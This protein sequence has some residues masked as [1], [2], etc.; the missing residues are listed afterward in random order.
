VQISGLSQN[1]SS[2]LASSSQISSLPV[3]TGV[4][5][6]SIVNSLSSTTNDL[7]TISAT[8]NAL[9]NVVY[10]G[11]LLSTAVSLATG[12]PL[13]LP[14][15]TNNVNS[16]NSLSSA[17]GVASDLL[18]NVP[19]AALS[20]TN[21][22]N[23]LFS[24]ISLA[25]GLQG[26]LPGSIVPNL[27]SGSLLPTPVRVVNGL[28]DNVPNAGVVTQGVSAIPKLISSAINQVRLLLI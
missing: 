14:T 24:A 21:A 20:N 27:S 3:K 9:P 4:G 17:I 2:I 18:G 6:S 26:N 22:G 16:G 1:P 19:T 25:T 15:S 10:E 12:I 8:Q 11:N 13:S 7:G 23:L 5:G 28:I